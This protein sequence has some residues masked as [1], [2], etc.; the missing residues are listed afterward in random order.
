MSK[1]L[2][3]TTIKLSREGR[4]TVNNIL[5]EVAANPED[6][7]HA[8]VALRTERE[9]YKLEVIALVGALQESRLEVAILRTKRKSPALR[10]EETAR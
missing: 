7:A 5:D 10:R 1:L 4:A 3:E 6:A 8:I 2:P 9:E